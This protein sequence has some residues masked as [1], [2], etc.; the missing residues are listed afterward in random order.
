[1]E[2]KIILKNEEAEE[3]E[4]YLKA[5][6]GF[7][8]ESDKKEENDGM[9]VEKIE[10]RKT[11]DEKS[12]YTLYMVTNYDKEFYGD[13]IKGMA[14][15]NLSSC[16]IYDGKEVT[17]KGDDKMLASLI[18]RNGSTERFEG[19]TPTI[20]YKEEMDDAIKYISDH[21]R[22]SIEAV[23]DKFKGAKDVDKIKEMSAELSRAEIE[24]KESYI[25]GKVS[26]AL[27]TDIYGL[28]VYEIKDESKSLI[29]RAIEEN[30]TLVDVILE[31]KGRYVFDTN[32]AREEMYQ[33]DR[34]ATALKFEEEE[35]KRNER[36]LRMDIDLKL[37]G[38]TSFIFDPKYAYFERRKKED[39]LNFEY[40]GATTY[41][42]EALAYLIVDRKTD[43]MKMFVEE[44]Q[45]YDGEYRENDG[46][47]DEDE[48]EIKLSKEEEAFF[49]KV[50][51]EEKAKDE[52]V[53]RKHGIE[54]D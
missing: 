37:G 29:D 26:Y 28:D 4:S 45:Y 49:R 3:F 5:V 7:L 6:I 27:A 24:G 2:T 32:G 48:T 12:R 43:E 18:D 36:S 39:L 54:L 52:K 31:T 50:Y 10:T 23:K 15:D 53:R 16:V 46:I 9:K 11:D 30:R 40:A 19:L 51:E 41:D 20:G 13:K 38:K 17:V 47:V 22:E 25:S 1:M 35:K 42:C 14:L 21:L 34:I 33:K 8:N 44:T